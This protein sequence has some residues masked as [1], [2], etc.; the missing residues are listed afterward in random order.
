MGSEEVL[1]E[2]T[3][4]LSTAEFSA[5]VSAA[6]PHQSNFWEPNSR[7]TPGVFATEQ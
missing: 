2:S 5:V 6:P 7:I 4:G 1:H 3:V